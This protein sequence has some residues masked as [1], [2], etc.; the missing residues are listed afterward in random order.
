MAL[1]DLTVEERV[2]F[3]EER[4]AHYDS[5]IARLAAYAK[6]TP[7]GRLLLKAVGLK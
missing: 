7:T 5:L 1:E 4:L 3:L 2:T 6:L